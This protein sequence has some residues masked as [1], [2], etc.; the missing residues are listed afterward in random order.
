[1]PVLV[2]FNQIHTL[3]EFHS[4]ET[5]VYPGLFLGPTEDNI[6]GLVTRVHVP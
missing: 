6:I 5:Y 4:V 1:M 3:K 2:V